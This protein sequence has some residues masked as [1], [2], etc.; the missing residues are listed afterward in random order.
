MLV[1]Q[2]AGYSLIN[3]AIAVVVILAVMALVLLACRQFGIP[4]PG[5]IWQVVGIVLV[6]VVVIV[7][8]KFV[9]SL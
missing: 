9:A 6:A 1:A 4:F 5:W 8:I 3:L 2:V 7:A